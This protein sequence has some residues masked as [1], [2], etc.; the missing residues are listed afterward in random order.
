MEVQQDNFRGDMCIDG[1][2]GNFASALKYRVSRL[3]RK[4]N[5]FRHTANFV[6]KKLSIY[7]VI[8]LNLLRTKK[9]HTGAVKQGLVRIAEQRRVGTE[10][11]K[12]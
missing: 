12:R 2:A 10:S 8:S 4:H 1:S 6:S 5:S 11:L 9:T 7:S 3:E